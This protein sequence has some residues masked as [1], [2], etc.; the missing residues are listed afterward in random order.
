MHGLLYA[1][2]L[3]MCGELEE[4]MRAMVGRFAEVCRK[5]GLKANAAKSKV[6]I[7]NRERRDWSVRFT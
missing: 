7:L 3:V 6:R 5:R 1:D 2:V 4:D